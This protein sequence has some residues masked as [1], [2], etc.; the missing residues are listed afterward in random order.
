VSRASAAK[1]AATKRAAAGV[2]ELRIPENLV[3]V[4]GDTEEAI[5]RKRKKIKQ[6]KSRHRHTKKEEEI[7]TKQS[8]WQSF[9]TKKKGKKRRTG[10][11][12]GQKKDSQFRSGADG[13]VGIVGSGRGTTDYIDKK[14]HKHDD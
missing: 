11:F 3:I 9:N 7:N 8:S 14:R 4:E 13:K 10:F 2:G 6:L 12:S 1:A 5:E